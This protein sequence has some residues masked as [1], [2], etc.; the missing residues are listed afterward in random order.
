MLKSQRGEIQASL[1]NLGE[2]LT[3]IRQYTG[4]TRN[5]EFL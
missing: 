2:N 1:D 3:S 4:K 5:I